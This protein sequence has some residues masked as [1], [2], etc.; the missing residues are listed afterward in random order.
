MDIKN[1]Q[2]VMSKTRWRGPIEMERGRRLI[3]FVRD[4][5]SRIEMK[6]EMRWRTFKSAMEN[7]RSTD[8]N[9]VLRM[10]CWRRLT[11]H[12][13][14]TLIVCFLLGFQNINVDDK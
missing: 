12:L 11:P 9:G 5:M 14:N 3:A 13:E 6:T 7:W 8:S 1:L 2:P 10:D 4:E